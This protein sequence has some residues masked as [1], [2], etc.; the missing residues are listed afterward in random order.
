MWDIDTSGWFYYRN[1]FINIIIIIISTFEYL[2]ICLGPYLGHIQNNILREINYKY[3]RNIYFG[4]VTYQSVY[5]TYHALRT[6]IAF[7][8]NIYHKNFPNILLFLTL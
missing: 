1:L 5:K 3:M 8:K 4:R 6:N 7:P 2:A